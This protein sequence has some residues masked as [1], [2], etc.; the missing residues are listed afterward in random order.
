MTITNWDEAVVD[1]CEGPVHPKRP[2]LGMREI[3]FGRQV[4]VL[5]FAHPPISPICRTPFSPYSST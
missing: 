3:P 4:F 2:E 1:M 5:F